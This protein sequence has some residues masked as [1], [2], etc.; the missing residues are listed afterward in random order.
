MPRLLLHITV[1]L[2]RAC[3]RQGVYRRRRS[4]SFRPWQPKIA[5]ERA[6]S[7]VARGGNE[8]QHGRGGVLILRVLPNSPAAAIGLQTGDRIMAVG[9]K[10]VANYRDVARL[11]ALYRPN[12]RVDLLIDRGGWSRTLKATLGN[13]D[14]LSVPVA[15]AGQARM[16][17]VAPPAVAP[18]S[19]L[20]RPFYE[21]ETPADID[22]QHGY[23][24]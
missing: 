13:A 19:L 17:P 8:R 2:R 20:Q 16:A 12:A 24:G 1:F 21:D 5:R 23:G 22:D 4:E 18:G 14:A 7:G 10:P 11:V 3:S 9:G 6:P 15:P